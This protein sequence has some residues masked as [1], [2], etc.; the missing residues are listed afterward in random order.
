MAALHKPVSKH[1]PAQQVLT[2][3][4]VL[5]VLGGE[6]DPDAMHTGF[7]LPKTLGLDVRHI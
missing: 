2:L 5:H 7:L 4:K 6:R 3:L 1:V